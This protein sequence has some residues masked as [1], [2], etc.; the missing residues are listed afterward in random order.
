MKGVP[1]TTGGMGRGKKKD[2]K[3]PAAS[4][5]PRPV[6]AENVVIN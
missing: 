4:N 1:A 5:E 6:T 2:K 3:A